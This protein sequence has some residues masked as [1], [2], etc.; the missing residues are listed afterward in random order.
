MSRYEHAPPKTLGGKI[1][2]LTCADCNHKASRL[3][4]LAMMA[5]KA[6][7]DHASGRGTK[8]EMDFFGWGITSGYIRQKDDEAADCRWPESRQEIF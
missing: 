6:R 2:C 4:R 1:V 3:D 7:D 8:V 5:K